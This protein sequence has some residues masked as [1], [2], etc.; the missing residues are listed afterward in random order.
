M[1]TT[2]LPPRTVL[3]LLPLLLLLLLWLLLMLLLQLLQLLL[4]LPGMPFPGLETGEAAA[5]AAVAA[6]GL[7]S[8]CRV[9]AGTAQL[10]LGRAPSCRRVSCCLR[11]RCRPGPRRPRR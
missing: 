9:T 7:V 10:T 1:L 5:A 4:L 8:C 6:A 2:S 3:P 11:S